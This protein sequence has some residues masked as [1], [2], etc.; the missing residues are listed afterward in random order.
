MNSFNLITNSEKKNASWEMALGRPQHQL[1]KDL[2][3]FLFR[4]KSFLVQLV[5]IIP[6]FYQP[7]E[8]FTASDKILS[9][10]VELDPKVISYGYLK[11]LPQTFLLVLLFKVLVQVDHTVLF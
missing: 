9:A 4:L 10:S 1:V 11:I 8:K 7:M 3:T 2:R 6:Y 5:N